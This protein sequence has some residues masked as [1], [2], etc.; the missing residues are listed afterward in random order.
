MSYYEAPEGFAPDPE[1]GLY[2]REMILNDDAANSFRHIVYF[3]AD[4]GEYTQE[5]IPLNTGI[6]KEKS[7]TAGRTTVRTRR[8]K[9]G[10]AGR[11][12]RLTAVVVPVLLLLFLIVILLMSDRGRRKLSDDDLAAYRDNVIVEEIPSQTVQAA[13][14]EGNLQEGGIVR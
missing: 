4:T 2:K 13:P 1:T 9:A 7:R 6:I 11:I 12:I 8:R 10:R 5:T 14:Y 3:D